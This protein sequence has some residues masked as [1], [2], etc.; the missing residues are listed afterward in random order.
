MFAL[1]PKRSIY[2]INLRPLDGV[3]TKGNTRRP[4]LFT[5]VIVN[6]LQVVGLS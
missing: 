5:Y 6:W 2:G 3:M 1:R 4:K